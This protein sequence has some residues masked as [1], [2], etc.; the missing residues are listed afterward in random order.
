MPIHRKT[1]II[2]L[3]AILLIILCLTVPARV[4]AQ[5][6]PSQDAVF[7]VDSSE[8]ATPYLA[9]ITGVLSR[10]AGGARRGDSVTCYQFSN[11]PTLIAK[12][13]IKKSDDVTQ[14]KSQLSHLYSESVSTNYYPALQKGLAEIK[15]SLMRSPGNERVLI[16]ITDGR[17]HP[18]DISDESGAFKKALDEFSGLQTERDYYFYCFVLGESRIEDLQKY[19][20]SIGAY[21]IKWPADTQWLDRLALADVHIMDSVR[22]IGQIPDT[23]SHG[24]FTISF[25]PRRASQDAPTLEMDVNADFVKGTLDRFFSVRPRR[26]VCQAEPWTETFE[27]ETRGFTRGTYSGVFAFRPSDPRSLLVSPRHADFSFSVAESLR[28]TVSRPLAFG[29]TGLKGEY[30]ETRTIFITASG[31]DFPESLDEVSVSTDIR[32]PEG[33]ELKLSPSLRMKTI[34]IGVTVRRSADAPQQSK[35]KYEGRVK[36]ASTRGWAFSNSEIPFSVDVSARGINFGRVIRVIVIGV[37]V[38]ILVA[39]LLLMSGSVRRAISDRLAHKT[40]AIGKLLVTH[41]PTKG[42]ARHI[43]LERLSEERRTKEISLGVGEGADVE[44]PH[45]SMMDRRY[46]FSGLRT[47]EGVRTIVRATKGTDEVIVNGMP[48]TGGVQLINFDNL[49]L[50]AFEYRYEVPT[51]LTQTILYFLDGEVMQGWPLSWG[52]EAEGFRFLSRGHLPDR[53]E[54]YVRFYELKVT[55]F[56]R[57]FEGELTKRL[58]SPKAPRSGHLVKLVF[59]DEEVIS[60]FVLDWKNL[61]PK[62]YL[63]PDAM[64]DNVMFFFIDRHTLK[65]IVVL[66]E[67]ESGAVRARRMFADLLEQMKHNLER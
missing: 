6:I 32:L 25:Y 18:D 34:E 15:D 7:L 31:A 33:L 17:R 12:G 44:L 61:G 65:D 54:M 67:D 20:V 41:D 38:I 58:R 37:G 27:F 53:K 28:V 23:P 59:P 39:G 22:N 64:G 40:G 51:P 60:G 56:V 16:L 29:P 45:Y 43:N 21:F 49:K 11:K 50:G 13:V 14:L 19:L 10:F 42:M 8:S 35:Q 63:F 5:E 3:P 48:R 62:F 55:A 57:D 26:V 46:S 2:H 24:V 9:S 30:E 52:H 36:L 66:K 1:R 47:R 4:L